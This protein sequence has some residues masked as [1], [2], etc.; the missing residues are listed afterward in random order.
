MV[1][2]SV[3]V[4]SCGKVLGITYA[5]FGLIFGA[6]FA[7]FA[8]AGAAMPQPPQADG[9]NPF[10]VVAGLGVAAVIV[11]PIMYGIMGF[12]GGIIAALVYNLV[13]SVVGGLE[14]EFDPSNPLRPMS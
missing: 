2:R 10:A 9:P 11:V 4:L 1:L 14:L 5:I 8:M 12:I 7:L 3:G 13:A 6:F